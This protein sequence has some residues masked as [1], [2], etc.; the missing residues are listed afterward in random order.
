MTPDLAMARETAA[1]AFDS[2]CAITRDAEGQHDDWRDYGAG[3]V[4]SGPG[5]SSPVWSGPCLLRP[6]TSRKGSEVQAGATMWVQLWR[7]RIAVEAGIVKRG[8]T[9]TVTAC[10]NDT[11]MVG[12][13]LMVTEIEG[14]TFAVTRILT[15]TVKDRGPEL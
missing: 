8:D 1:Q 11:A 12:A 10:P 14:G 6:D 15:C 9:V 7:V 3:T 13:R 5:D 4:G 2:E